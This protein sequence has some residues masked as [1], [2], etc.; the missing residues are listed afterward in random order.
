MLKAVALLDK[1]AGVTNPAV[2]PSA[3]ASS[4]DSLAAAAASVAAV[5]ANDDAAETGLLA[6]FKLPRDFKPSFDVKN[7]PKN[8]E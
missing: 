2:C 7:R 1:T 5:A 3:L 8:F 4:V 6:R